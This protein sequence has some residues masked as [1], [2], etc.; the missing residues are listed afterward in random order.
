[1]GGGPVEVEED[2]AVGGGGA[3]GEEAG[4]SSGQNDNIQFVLGLFNYYVINVFFSEASH[5]L[6]N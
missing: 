5:P 3:R 1:M 6:S 2:R 4:L